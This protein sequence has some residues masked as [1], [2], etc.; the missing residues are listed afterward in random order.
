M[1][2]SRPYLEPSPRQGDNSCLTD[3]FTLGFPVGL[4]T[5]MSRNE[6]VV[7]D[8]SGLMMN[9]KE[10]LFLFLSLSQENKRIR[11]VELVVEMRIPSLPSFRA[12][13]GS[14]AFVLVEQS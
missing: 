4:L 9:R 11:V 2:D 7:T 1:F 8:G 13:F 5:G 10:T 6:L 12:S 14:K 3:G